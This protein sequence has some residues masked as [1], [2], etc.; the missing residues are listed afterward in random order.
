MSNA[1]LHPIQHQLLDIASKEDISSFSLGQLGKRLD[2]YPQIIK[3]HWQQ[4]DKKGLL[5]YQ[6]KG[7]VG[8]SNF[9][10]PPT[11]NFLKIPV[12]GAVTAGPTRIFAEQNIE[13]YLKISTTLRKSNKDLYA[14]KVSGESMNKAL[15]K[16]KP[17][18][19][20]SH[21]IVSTADNNYQT[22]DIVVAAIDGCA[23][24]KRLEIGDDW[25]KL[26]PDSTKTYQ[27]IILSQQ[28]GMAQMCGKVIE[29]Y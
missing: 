22:G 10:L 6:P 19:D 26:N 28:E 11:F 7:T 5:P 23:T 18:R 24:I 13:G 1:F 12:M 29:V 8:V 21:A 14:V 25:I 27:P 2:V 17:I 20:G 9:S 16:G 15:V 3:H 4:L